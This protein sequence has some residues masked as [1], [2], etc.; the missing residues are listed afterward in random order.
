M[1]PTIVRYRH[2]SKTLNK[3]LK[4]IWDSKFVE[5]LFQVAEYFIKNFCKKIKRNYV[6]ISNYKCSKESF[7]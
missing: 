7:I 3:N 1:Q 6:D 5:T 2:R 4:T